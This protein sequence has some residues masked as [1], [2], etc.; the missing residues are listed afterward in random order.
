[1]AQIAHRV[2]IRA[3]LLSLLP[4]H[5]VETEMYSYAT[6]LRRAELAEELG[7]YCLWI[8]EHHVRTVSCIL[9]PAV[10]LAAAR[11]LRRWGR[12]GWS[13]PDRETGLPLAAILHTETGH[14][15]PSCFPYPLP[16]AVHAPGRDE[17]QARRQDAA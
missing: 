8:A 17:P 14:E 15:S 2:R 7:F 9:N 6:G 16:R 4:G 10:F 13:G 1:M 11:V 3:S 5:R 12:V